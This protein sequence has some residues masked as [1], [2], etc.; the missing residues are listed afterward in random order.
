MCLTG[1]QRETEL[2]E[3]IHEHPLMIDEFPGNLLP[4]ALQLSR[5][6]YF[7][8][9]CNGCGEQIKGS[10]FCCKK[11]RVFLHLS[12]AKLPQELQHPVHDKHP[13]VFHKKSKHDKD[14][15][16]CNHCNSVCREFFYH[17]LLCKFNLDIKC[18]STLQIIAVKFHDHPL[19]LFQG[20]IPFMCDFC[21]KKG[22]GMPCLCAIC[23][24]W[25]DRI[26]AS[27]PSMVKH[28]R[29][30]HPLN[31]TN[32]LKPYQSEHQICQICVKNVNTK[33]GIYYCSRCDYVAHLD[34][35]TKME[36]RELNFEWKLEEES[37]EP[38]TKV[39]EEKIEIP[40]EIKH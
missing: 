27:L 19:A 26:C 29:H 6:G 3:F 37:V 40:I 10:C 28:I 12:C 32:Y 15:Y 5:L 11:C 34:C 8:I 24:F 2:R 4:S 7:I 35:A 1:R 13:L 23:G 30:K 33:Y 9:N 20:S 14:I 17:C 39:K 18:A 31:L 21:G 25:V 38:T 36:S 16:K 22:R